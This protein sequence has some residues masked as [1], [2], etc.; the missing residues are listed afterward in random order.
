MKTPSQQRGQA[1]TKQPERHQIQ[2]QFL[3]LDQWLDKDHRARVVWQYSQSVD[4][5][6]IY[7]QIDATQGNVGRDAID[8]R[9][10]FALWM[11]ATLEGFSSARRLAKLT[12]RDIPYMWICGG[13][14]VN[15]HRLSDFRVDHRDL[16]EQIMVDSIGVLLHQKLITLET[17]AQDGMRVRASAGKSSFRSEQGLEKCLSRAQEHLD[18]IKANE[19]DDPSGDQRRHEA[20]AARLAQDK[21]DRIQS[22]QRELKILKEQRKKNGLKKGR[23]EPRASVTDPEARNM[24]MGDGGFRPAFNVQ[25]ASDGDT[26]IVVGVD[27]LSVGSD[28]GQM[29]PMHQKL[30]EDYATAPKEYLVDGGF[31]ASKDI[32]QLA[33]GGTT[34]YGV[35]I[36]AEKQ[37]KE[38]KD[39]YSAKPRDT[40]EMVAFR[41]RMG[42]QEAQEKYSQR[43]GIAEFPNAECRNR[44]L[45]QFRVRGRLKA[46]AQT[47]WNILAHNFNRFCHLGYLQRLTTNN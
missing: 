14:S 39:P 45:T 4:L 15:Y 23:K 5:S 47:M 22:A 13:V 31:S 8:P 27:V 26:R 10:L 38:G 17:V 6:E 25:F 19:A 11:L 2:M 43:A 1:R 34:V 44:G 37:I 28:N 16:L 42:T 41:K 40:P 12:T 24:K 29:A 20:S 7:D 46:K 3:S 36:N 33:Q 9:I 21:I 32:T 30:R 35:I 18:E